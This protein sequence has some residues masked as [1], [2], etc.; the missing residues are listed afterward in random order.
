MSSTNRYAVQITSPIDSVADRVY[1]IFDDYE[2]ALDWGFANVDNRN[3]FQVVML[4]PVQDSSP[5][6][7]ARIQAGNALS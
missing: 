3:V 1:G 7:K 4:T 5:E 6:F 2:S